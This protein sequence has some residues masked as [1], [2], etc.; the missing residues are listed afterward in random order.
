[1]PPSAY[2]PAGAANFAIELFGA[3]K[4]IIA[5]ASVA[6]PTPNAT[7]FSVLELV[8]PFSPFRGILLRFLTP[9]KALRAVFLIPPFFVD[10]R[11]FVLRLLFNDTNFLVAAFCL[12]LR[13][14]LTK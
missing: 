6:P 12:A 8:K 13:L 10:E 7:F 14:F 9:L 1:M 2:A 5:V 4:E 11:F 3:I